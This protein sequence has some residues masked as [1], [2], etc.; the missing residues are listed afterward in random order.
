MALNPADGYPHTLEYYA[1]FAGNQERQSFQFAKDIDTAMRTNYAANIVNIGRN[2]YPLLY[3]ESTFDGGRYTLLTDAKTRYVHQDVGQIYDVTKAV[4]HIPLGIFSIIS[5]YGEYPAFA[6][7]IPALQTYRDQISRVQGTFSSISGM[8]LEDKITI[9]AMLSESLKFID[10]IISAGAFTNAEFA[11]YAQ[12]IGDMILYCQN[13]AA[14]NQVEIM[15]NVLKGWKETIGDE[16][17]DKMYVIIGAVWTL[18]QEN[19]HE[20]IIKALMKPELRDTHVVVS[21]AVPDLESA[22]TLMGRIVGDRIMAELVFDTKA[23]PAFAQDI[24]SLSTRRDL[25]S[26]AVEQVVGNVA[27]APA[28]TNAGVA[29]PHLRA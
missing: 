15:T 6:Q 2:I 1:E 10:K 5:G 28:S 3:V 20:L 21:E 25:L 24:Y 14:K 13:R 26:Q 23:N 16:A 29:C 22:Q 9:D 17:W 12:S 11:T 4:S 7:W 27:R 8:T 18:T 19:A